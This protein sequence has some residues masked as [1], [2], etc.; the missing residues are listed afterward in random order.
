MSAARM[1]ETVSKAVGEAPS[2]TIA[3]MVEY[4]KRA[5]EKSPQV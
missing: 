3:K 1:V 5:W 4:Y 2:P